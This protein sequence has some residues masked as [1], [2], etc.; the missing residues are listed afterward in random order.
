MRVRVEFTTEPFRGE[1]DLPPHVTAAAEPLAQ[2]GLAPDL[3]PLGTYVEGEA[4]A[5]VPVISAVVGAALREGATRV[6]LQ[7]ERVDD[8]G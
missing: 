5:V 1:G 3:G 4:D 6:T 7:V 2:A 8:A